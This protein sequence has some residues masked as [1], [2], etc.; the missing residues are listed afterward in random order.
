[1]SSRL[2]PIVSVSCGPTAVCA[3]TGATSALAC[4]TMMQAVDFDGPRPSHLNDSA[5]RHQVRA[6]EML[7]FEISNVDGRLSTQ[8]PLR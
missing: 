3:V 2:H 4:E 7:G 8:L 5:F 6:V 1:M